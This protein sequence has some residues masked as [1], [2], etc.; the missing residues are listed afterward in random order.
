MIFSPQ[1]TLTPKI[2]RQIK[3]IESTSGFLEAVRLRPDWIHGVRAKAQVQEALNSVQIE[4][5]TLTLEEAFALAEQLPDRALHDSEREFC[6]YLRSFEALDGFQG[7]RSAVLNKG[8]LLNLHRLLVD[9]VRGGS[10]YAGQLRREEVSVGDVVNG[11]TVVHHAPPHW[12]QVEEEVASLLRWIEES[13]NYGN[14]GDGDTWVHPVIQ[15]GISQHRLVWIHPFI[16]GN[17]RTARMLTT[18]L[19]YQRGYDFK[20]LFELSGYYNRDRDR[21]YKALRSADRTGDYTE[22]LTYFLGGFSFQMVTIKEK[23]MEAANAGDT[24]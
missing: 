5:N 22:W 23:A 3:A 18:L 1:F 10:R 24:A 13:K 17:G 12:A 20:Y 11:E 16:D 14:N 19:L 9:G 2:Q 21:Y 6:N 15:A 7:D 4:G 8:D